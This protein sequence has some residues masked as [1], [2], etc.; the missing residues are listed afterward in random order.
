VFARESRLWYWARDNELVDLGQAGGDKGASCRCTVAWFA[1]DAFFPV[2][3]AFEEAARPELT[4]VIPRGGSVRDA[5]DRGAMLGMANVISVLL[6]GVH[7]CTNVYSKSMLASLVNCR[8][9][10]YCENMCSTLPKVTRL[11]R[12]P[13]HQKPAGPFAD[14]RPHYS[15]FHRENSGS[16]PGARR[17]AALRFDV[18]CLR[19]GCVMRPGVH[20]NFDGQYA[21]QSRVEYR[22]GT[23]HE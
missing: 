22:N 3:D 10:E 15:S 21:Q 6:A 13:L 12:R 14:L 18:C 19:F 20:P 7:F 1:S 17:T 2:P 16:P 23:T 9:Q 8:D 11:K 4:A 5:I